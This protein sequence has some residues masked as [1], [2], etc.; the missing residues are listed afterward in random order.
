MPL[1]D[2]GK[3]ILGQMKKKYGAEKGKSVF[4]ASI[5]ANKPGSEDWHMSTVL[6]GA[7]KRRRGPK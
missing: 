7:K 2:T 3:T 5:N 1:T 6:G 4:Y